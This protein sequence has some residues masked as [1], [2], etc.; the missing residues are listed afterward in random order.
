MLDWPQGVSLLKH[1][2]SLGTILLK[3]WGHQETVCPRTT[4]CCPSFSPFWTSSWSWFQR[5][6]RQLSVVPVLVPF[7]LAHGVGSKGALGQ[8]GVVLVSTLWVTLRVGSKGALRAIG[9]PGCSK[10]DYDLVSVTSLTCLGR[11]SKFV[12]SDWDI[13]TNQVCCGVHR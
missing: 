3:L 7:E 11:D 5:A 8:L 2:G 4:W 10:L 9:S 6:P 13:G 1:L 12:L